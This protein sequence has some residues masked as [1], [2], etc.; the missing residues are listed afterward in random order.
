MKTAYTMSAIAL[1]LAFNLPGVGHAK[2]PVSELTPEQKAKVEEAKV[3]AADAAKHQ[4]ELLGKAQDRVA[5]NY[6]K[7]KGKAV[8]SATAPAA[9]STKK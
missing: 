2:L 1:L 7:S 6:R 8:A 5:D 3:K 9:P 4:A